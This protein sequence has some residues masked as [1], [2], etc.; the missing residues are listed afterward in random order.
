[1][2]G[3]SF[4]GGEGWVGVCVRLQ[5]G[6]LILEDPVKILWSKKWCGQNGQVTASTKMWA[7]SV[8]SKHDNN[9]VWISI[10]KKKKNRQNTNFIVLREFLFEFSSTAR[11]LGIVMGRAGKGGRQQF[12]GEKCPRMFWKKWHVIYFG[13]YDLLRGKNTHEMLLRWKKR[14]QLFFRQW[15]RCNFLPL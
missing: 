9:I 12:T 6:Y 5:A 10:L 8:K 14:W 3:F 2:G 11:A 7:V 4:V 13:Q 1:M 15:Q